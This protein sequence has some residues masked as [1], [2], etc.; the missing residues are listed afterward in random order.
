M[1]ILNN[2]FHYVLF[3]SLIPSANFIYTA[4]QPT[5]GKSQVDGFIEF[6]LPVYDESK[7]KE[8][9]FNYVT[10]LG[11]YLNTT[12]FI[13]LINAISSHTGISIHDLINATPQFLLQTYKEYGQ[14]RAS[15]LPLIFWL[16]ASPTVNLKDKKEII[17]YLINHGANTN[18]TVPPLSELPQ[19]LLMHKYVREGDTLLHIA[20]R[21]GDQELFN[22]LASS[23]IDPTIR[24]ADGF[25]AQDILNRNP[26]TSTETNRQESSSSRVGS[27]TINLNTQGRRA[28]RD[29]MGDFLND[30]RSALDA[31]A[32]TDT[33]Q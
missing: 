10:L 8:Q 24:N 6:L 19:S 14:K 2:F 25:T 17:E 15:Q 29:R 13:K 32:G 18:F 5:D 3:A 21:I 30:M 7:A 28:F 23:G 11:E 27:T 9:L 4:E 22:I 26:Q 12:S 1:K 16:I 33:K 20:A 31:L